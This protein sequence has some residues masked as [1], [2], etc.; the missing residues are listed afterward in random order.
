MWMEKIVQVLHKAVYE[1]DYRLDAEDRKGKTSQDG[2]ACKHSRIC[3]DWLDR[4]LLSHFLL[5]G[6]DWDFFTAFLLFLHFAELLGDITP[7][8]PKYL[9]MLFVYIIVGLSLV[10]MC[11]NLIQVGIFNARALKPGLPPLT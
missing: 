8:Q 6:N 4:S 3:G 5:V 7:N 1:R 2:L 9:L 11:V 10:S